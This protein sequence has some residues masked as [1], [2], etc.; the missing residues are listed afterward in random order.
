MWCFDPLTYL[1]DETNP[2]E[3][4]N[5]WKMMLLQGIITLLLVDIIEPRGVTSLALFDFH[6]VSLECAYMNSTTF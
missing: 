3:W 4:K 6:S 2:L 1:S 5:E